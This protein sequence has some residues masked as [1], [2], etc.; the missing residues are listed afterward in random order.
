MQNDRF[1]EL[2]EVVYCQLIQDLTKEKK[3]KV[4]KKNMVYC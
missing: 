1:N 4:V 3:E 2:K